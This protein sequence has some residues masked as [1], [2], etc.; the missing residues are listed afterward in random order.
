MLFQIHNPIA[1]L[2][3]M[4]R[5]A[6]ISRLYSPTSVRSGGLY[7]RYVEELSEASLYT[8]ITS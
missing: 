8:T 5:K 6:E 4:K 1:E 3:R 2:Y 7:K